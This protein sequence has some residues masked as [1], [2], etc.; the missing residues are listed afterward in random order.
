MMTGDERERSYK[1]YE[2]VLSTPSDLRRKYGLARTTSQ[3]K[4][5]GRGEHRQ[6]IITMSAMLR[7]KSSKRQAETYHGEG[8]ALGSEAAGSAGRGELL[9]G[10]RVVGG[11]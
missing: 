5:R 6:P 10:L 1:S 11:C 3:S 7:T 9:A 2:K 8:A 4:E